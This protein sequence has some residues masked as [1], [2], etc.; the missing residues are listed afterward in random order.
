MAESHI[1][2]EVWLPSQSWNQRFRGLGNGGFAGQI[3]YTQLAD[4]IR[5]GYASAATD[6]G[7]EANG[8]DATWAYHHPEKV[9]DFGY[10]AVHLTA[11]NAKAVINAFYSESLQHSY[12]DGCSDGGREALMEAQRFPEDYDGILAGAPAN[13][14]THLVTSGLAVTQALMANP[15]AYISEL[16]LPAINAAVMAACDAGDGVKDGIIN[17]PRKC[18]FDPSTL[19]CHGDESRSCLTAPQIKALKAIYAGG[20]DAKGRQI[21]PGFMPGSE[22]GWGDWVTGNGPGLSA[23]NGF[24]NGYFRYIVME[25]GVWN[26]LNANLDDALRAADEKTAQA[27]NSTQADLAG[28]VSRGGKLIL[29]HGWNDPAISPLNTINYYESVRSKMGPAGTEGSV[30]L[31]MAPGVGHCFGGPGANSF[32]QLG[33]V[34][35]KGPKYGM[36]D[37]LQ[38]WVEKG[39][40]PDEIIGTKYT[41]DDR[42]KPVQ[43]TR[44]LCPYPQEAQYKG[45]GDPNDSANFS[46]AAPAQ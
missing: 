42:E 44:P 11:Q 24:V 39:T 37:A 46:C 5:R 1:Q 16:K 6:D 7:H 22:N 13:Y 36:F 19:L 2:F 40:P 4:S 32:G 34:T 31:Y 26:P 41:G 18:H 38:A 17:D 35:A 30:R 45:S 3:G 25:D 10:R 23:G 20:R 28:F 8:I 21:F 33:T 27:L 15:E 14:W 9:K 12:F 43:M 29:Y